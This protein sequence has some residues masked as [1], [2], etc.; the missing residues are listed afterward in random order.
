MNLYL[1]AQW[2]RRA[3]IARYAALLREDG[4]EVVSTWHE[5]EA[6]GD[7]DESRWEEYAK[8]GEGEI[9]SAQ[10]FVAFT[11]PVGTLSRGGR[12][13]EWGYAL[14]IALRGNPCIVVGPTESQ[15]YALADERF[16]DIDGMRAWL[17]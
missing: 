10:A 16:D 4:H 3:E 8:Q 17:A 7:H 13:I 1:S 12:H 6:G 14:G 2:S 9:I 11:E 15:F 5:G